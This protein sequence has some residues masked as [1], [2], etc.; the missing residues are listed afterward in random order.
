MKGDH[1]VDLRIVTVEEA[2]A[3]FREEL[4]GLGLT[5]EELDA[6]AAAGVFV[7]DRARLLWMASPNGMPYDIPAG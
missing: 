7:S 5:E 2:G 6:Q 3:W 4:E 1:D